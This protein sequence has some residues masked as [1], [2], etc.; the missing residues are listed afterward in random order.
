MLGTT[1]TGLGQGG[2]SEGREGFEGGDVAGGVWVADWAAAGIEAGLGERG[3]EFQ[4]P[5]AG[6]AHRGI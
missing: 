5:G 2:L 6:I 4:F 1:A 3:R